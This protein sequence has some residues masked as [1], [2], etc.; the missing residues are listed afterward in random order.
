[1]DSWEKFNEA[2]LP[3]KEPFYS[4]LN[5]ES[6]TDEDYVYAQKVCK[7][8]EIKNLGQYHMFKVILYYL[9]MYLKTLEIDV[10]IIINLILLIFCLLQD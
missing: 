5:L 7:L 10:L 8:F 9:Q 6:I 3:D 2:S 4:N 1:M